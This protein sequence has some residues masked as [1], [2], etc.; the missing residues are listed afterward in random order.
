MMPA[1]ALAL[2]ALPVVAALSRAAEPR[3]FDEILHTTVVE[4]Q[5]VFTPDGR[6]VVYTSNRGHGSITVT[7][8]DS[9]TGEMSV[10]GRVP[11]GGKTPRGFGMDPSGRWVVAA[12]QDAGTVVTFRR[13]AETGL[14]EETGNVVEVRSPVT[15]I[16]VAE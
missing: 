16:F 2:A 1:L 7:K 9:V 11:T 10:V 8:V 4:R 3:S 14:L 12:N 13:N 15:V 6:S 5:P